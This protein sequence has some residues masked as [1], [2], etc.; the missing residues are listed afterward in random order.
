MNTYKAFLLLLAGLLASLTACTRKEVRLEFDLD[1]QV[2]TPCRVIYFEE[3]RQG[4]VLRENVADVRNGKGRF[5]I[6]AYYP[7]LMF[8]YS[9]S[10]TTPAQVIYA[11]PGDDIKITGAGTDFSK[12]SVEGNATCRLLSEWHAENAPLL[13]RRDKGNIDK[14]VAKFVEAHP[15]SKAAA[16]LLYLYF[17]RRNSLAQFVKLEKK[18]N[19]DVTGD[20]DLMRA[21]ALADYIAGGA[22]TPSYPAVIIK[23]GESGYADTVRLDKGKGKLMIFRS[24]SNASNVLPIDSIRGFMSRNKQVEVVEF[25]YEADSTTWR[26]KI[27][28]DT[29]PGLRRLWLPLGPTDSVAMAMGVTRIPYIIALDT[30]RHELYR[31]DSWSQAAKAL[32]EK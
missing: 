11:N 31:G 1:P 10:G 23:T 15:D 29:L 21:L 12:W 19:K 4:G 20:K 17:D 5:R 13:L 30:L 9:T 3:G 6:P 22:S 27:A 24:S 8:L 32:Q 16:I 28:A 18:L 26:R 7:T 2:S 25:F 14:A